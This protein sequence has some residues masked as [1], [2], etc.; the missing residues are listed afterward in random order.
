MTRLLVS[1]RSVDEAC[2]ALAAGV[3]LIDLKE[4]ARGSLGPVDAQTAADVIA[5][6][7]GRA[8]LSMAAG[9]LQEIEDFEAEPLRL[10]YGGP[11]GFAYA[12][13]GLAGCARASDWSR[14]WAR[15][16]ERLPAGVAPVA[17]V[18]ADWRQ[19][20]A[21]APEEILA[22]AAALACRAVLIDTAGKAHGDLL[23]HFPLPQLQSFTAE[24]R[25]AGLLNVLAGSLS[26]ASLPQVLPLQPDYVAVR[27]AVCRGGRSGPL[28][29]QKLRQWVERLRGSAQQISDPSPFA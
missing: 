19:A 2:E 11:G 18:Y 12:K 21:P 1:V 10:S 24:I 8:P 4:P 5:A 28:D 22:H 27:G 3:D 6:I 26:Q 20:D 17:V 9:E 13:L 16:I 25:R 15:W 14:R 29:G 23:H 7:G